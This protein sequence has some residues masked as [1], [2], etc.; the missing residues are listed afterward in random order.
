MK[1]LSWGNFLTNFAVGS[2]PTSKRPT[3]RSS[4]Q[5]LSL[6]QLML[7]KNLVLSSLHNLVLH[8]FLETTDS[9]TKM[10]KNS[11]DLINQMYDTQP[12]VVKDT[13]SKNGF[14]Q[15]GKYIFY[16]EWQM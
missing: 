4:C 6:L 1:M 3:T 8:L 15:Q 12:Q 14:Y 9:N 16:K 5:L 11:M 13:I 2:R 7:Y 10:T